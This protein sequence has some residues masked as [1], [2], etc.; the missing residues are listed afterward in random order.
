M[1]ALSHAVPAVPPLHLHAPLLRL[2]EW[3][4]DESDCSY[5][6]ALGSYAAAIKLPTGCDLQLHIDAQPTATA[7]GGWFLQ[8][9]AAAAG[10]RRAVCEL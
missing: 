4:F 1:A 5:A 8:R 10:G 7:P 3:F 2:P 6:T 9:R